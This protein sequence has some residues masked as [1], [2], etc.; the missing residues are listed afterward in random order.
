MT[1]ILLVAF[2]GII[3]NGWFTA[4]SVMFTPE[5]SGIMFHA[6]QKSPALKRTIGEHFNYRGDTVYFNYIVKGVETK[7]IDFDSITKQIIYEP[8][9][10][11]INYVGLSD[12]S[13][14]ILAELASKMALYKL[15]ID[16]KN[17]NN[18]APLETKD[19]SFGKFLDTL[20][21]NLPPESLRKKGGKNEPTA[22]IAELLDPNLFFNQR[23]QALTTIQS[24]KTPKQKEVIDAI[25]KAIWSYLQFK[26]A[27]YFKKLSRE[28]RGF[29]TKLIACGDGSNTS[30]LLDEREKIYKQKNELG[31]AVG[32]GLFTYE[33]QFVATGNNRQVLIPKG[34]TQIELRAIQ[35]SYTNLHLSLWGFNSNNQTTVAIYN[36]GKMY[37][38]YGN[39]ITRELSPDST[40]GK[41]TTIHSAIARLENETIPMQDALINGK[42]GIRE[43]LANSDTNYRDVMMQIAQTEMNLTNYRYDAIKNK[44]KIK[45]D[46]NL[47]AKLY[48]RKSSIQKQQAMLTA[49]LKEEEERMARFQAR[50]I[51]L[52]G[53]LAYEQIGYSRF[54]YVY[55]FE[56]GCTF[57][58]FTQDFTIPDS[59][60]TDKF[61]VRLIAIGMDA[62]SERLDEVQLLTTVSKGQPED[63]ATHEV[64]LSLHDVFEVD[65]YVLSDFVFEQDKQFELIKLLYEIIRTKTSLRYELTGGGVGIMVNGK[66]QSSV[67]PELPS[68]PGE[69]EEERTLSKSSEMFRSLRYTHTYLSQSGQQL[70]L[71]IESFTDPVVSNFSKKV[72]A[73][74]GLR[75]AI[76]GSLTDNQ[77]LSVFRTF[78]MAELLSK[79]LWR[80]AYY[81]FNGKEKSLLMDEIKKTLYGS[82]CRVGLLNVTY[83]QYAAIAHA[84]A[85]FYEQCLKDFKLE[86]EEIKKILEN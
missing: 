20:V 18:N 47:L 78:H 37:L 16:L 65:S 62:M 84:K 17:R 59:I 28:T 10:L 70:I 19:P 31:D 8:S 34:S 21:L 7:I 66:V 4:Q 60:H 32:I 81:N 38:L 72:T 12:E 85:D 52:K 42:G 75:S 33:S 23:V 48:G 40:F 30:G 86:E 36:Q 57:N 79:E 68:Y 53:Y 15:Y 83:K 3:C 50:L 67:M 80:A 76:D 22:E 73:I 64:E 2:F 27:E 25:N 45:A 46:E 82:V 51:E 69:N 61:F 14:G 41:G 71:K 13:T 49:K 35:E 11:Y 29:T 44:K 39:K 55:T 74:D 54:G 26:S 24:L 1:K 43:K 77:L 63:F 5:E 56:D 6:V 58:T 9:L